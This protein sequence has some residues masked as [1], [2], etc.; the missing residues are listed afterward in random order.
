MSG[1]AGACEWQGLHDFN[2]LVQIANPPQGYMQNCNTS[3][4]NMMKNSPLVPEKWAAHPYLYN[5]G[6]TEHQREA[7]VREL[8]DRSA[9]ITPEQMIEI[10][11]SPEVHQ[12]ETWQVRVR[13]AAPHHELTPIITGWNRRSEAG[14]RA[15][16]VFA[17]FKTSLPGNAQQA[18][19][20]P[21]WLTDTMIRAA[22]DK[23]A[24]RL[25]TEVPTGAVFGT[26][27]RVGREGSAKTWPVSGG[28]V[29]NAG[30]A[31][32]RNIIFSRRGGLFVGNDGQSIT[33]VVALTKPPQS[34][35]AT[36]F[37]QSDHPESG[38]FEDQAEKLFSQSKLKSTYFL[39]RKELE[40]HVTARKEIAVG[41]WK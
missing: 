8:L 37:G 32:P 3:P 7:M 31:T 35:S 12:A 28:N 38:H 29:P 40:K 13:Q 2:E 36:P 1:A 21:G 4:I 34:W 41:S 39:N 19:Q 14:S 22:L 25:K 33:Q 20:P 16:L 18:A 24:Q 23:A 27:F 9:R 6:S 5:E 17:V 30:M 10:A 26:V 11:L 15:A